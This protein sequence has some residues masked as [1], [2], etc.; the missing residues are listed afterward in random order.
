[1]EPVKLRAHNLDSMYITKKVGLDAK[2]M[3]GRTILMD[4]VYGEAFRQRYIQFIDEIEDDT[5]IEIVS[6]NDDICDKLVCPYSSDCGSKNYSYVMNTMVEKF[7]PGT[8]P[9]VIKAFRM[10]TPEIGDKYSSRRFG[11]EP[12][13]VFRFGDIKVVDEHPPF[14]DLVNINSS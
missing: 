5:L 4:L 6:G 10:M 2:I 3:E 14:D 12:G 11:I 8:D 1:M 7:P 13:N 9:R